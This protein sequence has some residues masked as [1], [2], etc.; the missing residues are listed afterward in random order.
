MVE[1]LHPSGTAE[2]P[3]RH[4]G[5]RS[6]TRRSEAGAP[7]PARRPAHQLGSETGEAGVAPRPLQSPVIQNSAHTSTPASSQAANS[8]GGAHPAPPHRR[9]MLSPASAGGGG[10]GT[11]LGQRGRAAWQGSQLIPPM[12]E[13]PAPIAVA[14]V[15]AMEGPQRQLSPACSRTSAR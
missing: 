6:Q 4:G 10:A 9:I 1:G 7:P 11:Q 15:A 5:P 12:Q 2:G 14:T 8:S 13:G 3:W